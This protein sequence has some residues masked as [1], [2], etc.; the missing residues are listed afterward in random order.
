[1]D[2]IMA[3]TCVLST[4]R[5]YKDCIVYENIVNALNGQIVLFNTLQ[6]FSPGLAIVANGIIRDLVPEFEPSAEVAHMIA[7]SI[8]E[9]GLSIVPGGLRFAETL[10]A[11][12]LEADKTEIYSKMRELESGAQP[13]ED[14]IS[15]QAMLILAVTSYEVHQ[16]SLL[17]EQEKHYF[18]E[19]GT[20]ESSSDESSDTIS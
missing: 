14:R 13:S 12:G 4:D 10:K 7:A 15:D 3:L 16:K 8:R 5:T 20:D 9:Y 6:G 19:G 1:M 18:T 11:F 17:S 2:K